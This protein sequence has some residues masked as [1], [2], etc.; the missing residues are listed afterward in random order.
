MNLS[1]Y[2]PQQEENIYIRK[3]ARTWQRSGLI[4]NDQLTSIFGYTNP[5]V[6]QTNVFFR[7]IFFIFTYLCASALLGLFVWITGIKGSMALSVTS[8]IAGVIF[9]FLAEY[10]ITNYRFYRHGIEEALALSSMV[11]LCMGL[12]FGAMK[13][14]WGNKLSAHF[15]ILLC[16]LFAVNACWIYLRFGYL[17]AAL[18]SIVATC[19]I[20]FQLSLTPISERVLLLSILCLIFFLNVI[21][22]NLENEDFRKDKDTTIQTC[23]LAAIYLTVNLEI[24]GALGLLTGDTRS[25]HLHPKSFPP[26]IYWSSY[27]LT[28]IIPVAGIYWGIKSRKRLILN[29]SLIMACVTLATN[30]SYLGWT[31]YAWDPVILGTALIVLSI[32]INRWLNNGANKA[33]DGFTAEDILK[34]E[35]HGIG[36][37]EVA[38]ALTPI[39]TGIEV[40]HQEKYFDG[41]SSGGGG[42]SGNY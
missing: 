39:A 40:Q 4:T 37:A 6:S 7:A 16:I 27:I 29:A 25:I 36:L 11:L 10:A 9:Y 20:P 34:P 22:D 8:I 31:R 17:Y 19:I 2:S 35:N 41:G 30:K 23:L 26:Y 28:F 21:Y 12:F 14:F 5:D 1:L 15:D 3:Q 33:R 42:A 38:A 32:I 24:I 13:L 18:I